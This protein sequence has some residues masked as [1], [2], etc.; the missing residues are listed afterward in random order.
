ME[1][2]NIGNGQIALLNA[3]ALLTSTNKCSKNDAVAKYFSL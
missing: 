2:N 1:V 3:D